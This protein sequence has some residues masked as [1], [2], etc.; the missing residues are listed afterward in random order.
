[1]GLFGHNING[2]FAEYAM[3]KETG[4][5]KLP[6][7]MTWEQ[8][9][10]LEPLGVVVRPVF[11]AEVGM[12]TVCVAGCGP[13]GQ[14]AISLSAGLGAQKIYAVDINDQRLELAVKNGATDVINSKENPDFA[15]ILLKETGGLDV[16]IEASGNESVINEG[17]RSLHKC[18]KMYMVGNPKDDIVI[19]SPM[20]RLTLSEVTLK[21]NWGRSMFWTWDKAE[22]FLMSGKINLDNIITHRFK[23]SEYNEAFDI[24]L[25]G[26]GCKVLL[27]P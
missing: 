18:A 21:G 17:L 19:K 23:M 26:R 7:G 11:D 2:C 1:M 27:I 4:V 5:R 22:K 8:G 25:S 6:E 14:F 15:D 10:M 20:Q 13:I 12:S 24:A 3:V 16:F 9:A